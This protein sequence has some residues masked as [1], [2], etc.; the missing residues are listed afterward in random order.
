VPV[1]IEARGDVAVVTIDNPPVNAASHAV[2]AGLVDAVA[3]I[4]ADPALV[5]AVL[6]GAGTTFVAGADI[7][8]FDR[9]P[10][11]PHLP[12]VVAAIEGAAKPWVAAIHGAAL[13]GGLELA[14]GCRRRIAAPGARLGLPE[15]TLG[16]IPGAG[17]TVRLPRLIATRDALGLVAGGKPVPAAE[18]LP[19]GL[20][21]AV[22]DG[23]LLDAAVALARDAAAAAP[24]PPLLARPPRE[25]LAAADWEAEIAAQRRR[26]RGQAS[27]V[28][29]AEALRDAVTLD[30]AEAL[31][32]ER[33]RFLRLRDSDQARALRHVFFAE[34]ALARPADLRG[35]APRPTARAGVVGGGT[36]G[37][38]I[39]TAL[40]LAD[41]EVTL[42]ER[43][44]DA[45]ARAEAAV[46]ANLAEARSRGR[47]DPDGEAAAAARLRGAT[48]LAALAEADLV[49]EAVF[50]DMAVKTD[51]FARLGTI[52]RPEAILATNTSYLD[53][54][55]IAAAAPDPSRAIGLHFFSPAHVMR[56]L[57]IVRP[58]AVAA[59]VR[60]TGFALARDLGK[61]AVEAGVCEGFIGNRV[62]SAYRREADFMLEEGALPQEV[63]AAMTAFGFPMGVYAMQDLAGLDIAWA[64][65]KRLAATRDPAARYVAIA[66][67][68]CE[69]GRFGRKTGAG[70]YRYTDGKAAPDPA[71]EAE[72]L[73]ESAAKGLAR[74]AFTPHEIMARL[75]AAMQAEGAALLAE[76][77]ASGPEAVDAVMV[78]GYAFPRWRGGPMFMRAA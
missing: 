28:E 50:E 72:I 34:R 60:A 51:L 49:I 19:L 74:R 6:I 45:L 70:W 67:R 73:A 41:R 77:I 40:L 65:R 4:D 22:A 38:G 71:V 1:A 14:L 7:A 52:V 64:M 78:N 58:D 66:D 31:A 43:D 69:A 15:V 2:R 37:Q 36:M 5:A 54:N 3:R 53:V 75:L 57:E 48:D 26:A 62:M 47:L 10:E 21:D 17:G 27:P 20:I 23:P 39:A 56:L 16:L 59:D 11:P 9:P 25:P 32:A 76:G 61:V 42:V 35:V 63:D 13:G 55:R 33:A 18:A 24:E 46:R 29:A 44:M 12:D 30:P 8:E 68:L